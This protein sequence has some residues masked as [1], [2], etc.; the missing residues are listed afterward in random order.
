ML[1]HHNVLFA[2]SQGC[3]AAQ[4]PALALGYYLRVVATG[5]V[6]KLH[7][8]VFLL[9]FRIL[10]LNLN[11]LVTG[12]CEFRFRLTFKKIAKNPA[13]VEFIYTPYRDI[14]MEEKWTHI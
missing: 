10:A 11:P 2:L 3:A 8:A 1:P 9:F 7:Q 13:V 12:V 5:S 6:D 14:G 4:V